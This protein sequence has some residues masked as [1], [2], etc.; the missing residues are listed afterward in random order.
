MPRDMRTRGR[1]ARAI[2]ILLVALSLLAPAACARHRPDD[3]MRR[4]HAG[5]EAILDKAVLSRDP[6]TAF[7]DAIPRIRSFPS[8]DSA[9]TD[10]TTMFVKYRRGGTVTWTAPPPAKAP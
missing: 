4:D 7:K 8:V 10:G 2:G 9:W 1:Y 3:M 6:A 5:I